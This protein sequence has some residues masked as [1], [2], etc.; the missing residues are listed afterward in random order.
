MRHAAI[1]VESRLSMQRVAST[2][3]SISPALIIA[4]FGIWVVWGS[5]FFFTRTALKEWPPYWLAGARFVTAG[6]L[7]FLFLRMRGAVMPSRLQ[8]RNA[9]IVGFFLLVLGTGSTVFSQQWNTSGI[10]SALA[11]TATIWIALLSGLVLGAWPQRIE[12]IG[13]AVGVAGVLLLNVGAM[14]SGNVIGI[15]IGLFGTISWSV[16]TVLSLKLPLPADWMRTTAQMLIG[17]VVLLLI[18]VARGETVTLAASAQTW[19]AFGMLIIGSWLGFGSYMY[20]L[21]NAQLS[22][23]TSY[24]YMNPLVALLLGT[25]VAGEAIMPVEL[26]GVV[27]IL[28]SVAFIW[29]ANAQRLRKGR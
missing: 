11:A 6:T 24:A 29:L 20:L 17:G 28:A 23:A 1:G 16:G 10:A 15:A 3:K 25:F 5:M 21:A 26:L 13:I 9:G 18:S 2:S 8:W 7:S 19:G 22:L 4:V 14:T 27:V 12:W